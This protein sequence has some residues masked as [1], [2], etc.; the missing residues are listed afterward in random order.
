MSAPA[1]LPAFDPDLS[2]DHETNRAA[3]RARGLRYSKTQRAY[4]DEDGCPTLDQFGQR[5]G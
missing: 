2:P 3:A 5:L 1:K 4:L